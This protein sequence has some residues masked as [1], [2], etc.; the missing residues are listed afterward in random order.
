MFTGKQTRGASSRRETRPGSMLWDRRSSPRA[1]AKSTPLR[2]ASDCCR[3]TSTDWTTCDWRR[4]LEASARLFAGE[5]A[6]RC[7]LDNK[8]SVSSIPDRGTI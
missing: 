1:T 3:G 7:D 5:A 8:Q 4:E 2:A 6:A